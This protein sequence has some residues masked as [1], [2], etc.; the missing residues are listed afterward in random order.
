MFISE[1][2]NVGNMK[3]KCIRFVLLL[4]RIIY[5]M[6]CHCIIHR[7]NVLLLP[8][9]GS[10]GWSVASHRARIHNSLSTASNIIPTRKRK[11]KARKK[12]QHA[13]DISVRTPWTAYY[14]RIYRHLW[15]YI[16]AFR[17]LCRA[18]ADSRIHSRRLAF[19]K[20]T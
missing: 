19:T 8:R 15:N 7:P 6:R 20:T 18:A 17:T 14:T 3:L 11:E 9:I 4:L 1:R 16:H 10:V 2:P 13:N 12:Q 5:G